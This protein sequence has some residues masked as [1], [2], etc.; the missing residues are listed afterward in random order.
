MGLFGKSFII[1]TTP[2]PALNPLPPNGD[3]ENFDEFGGLYLKSEAESVIPAG[4]RLPTYQDFDSLIN[5]LGITSAVNRLK[6]SNPEY[7]AGGG[8]GINNVGFNGRAAGTAEI[9][10]ASF[11]THRFREV[12]SIMTSHDELQKQIFYNSNF[13][14]DAGDTSS[15]TYHS[16]RFLRDTASAHGTI[17][18]LDINGI[19]HNTIVIN[20]QEWMSENMKNKS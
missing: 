6:D 12:F 19:I 20:D 15:T 17:G 14:L 1:E 3:A 10:G 11:I 9:V 2:T 4:W 5:Y 18:V 16:V 8:E 13:P 7:W